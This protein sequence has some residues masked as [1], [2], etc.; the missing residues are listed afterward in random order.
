[1]KKILAFILI[2]SLSLFLFTSCDN[3]DAA[4]NLPNKDFSSGNSVESTGKETVAEDDPSTEDSRKI[5]KTYHLS[6]ETK[7]FKEDCTFIAT[8]AEKLGGYIASSSVSGSSMANDQ[9]SS[10]LA[11]YTVRIPSQSVDSYVNLI[12]ERCN[13]ISSNLTTEDITESYYGIR[14]Q[15]DSLVIQENNLLAML[16]KA[17]NLNE[18]IILG[19]KL[20]EIR[21]QINELNYKLQNMDK[22]ADYSYVYISLKEV[23]EYQ[24]AEK[25]YWQELGEAVT[26]SAKNFT[27]VLGTLLI[28]FVWVFP[29]VSV[30]AIAAAIVL[31][32]SN[33]SKRKKNKKQNE[34]KEH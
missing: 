14:A 13:V 25:T 4:V 32:V 29:F 33:R 5:I 28:V 20:S 8:E 30:I 19:D 24:T 22:S 27:D 9:T 15:I 23:L 26:D 21:A 12:S 1:M 6:L 31:V 11:R 10:Q 17:T 18:M 3:H 34:S 16:E 7:L 2:L